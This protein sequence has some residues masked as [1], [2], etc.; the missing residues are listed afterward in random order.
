MGFIK[1]LK[2][3]LLRRLTRNGDN[4]FYIPIH[5]HTDMTTDLDINWMSVTC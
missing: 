3:T 1:S 4:A 2:M 5:T